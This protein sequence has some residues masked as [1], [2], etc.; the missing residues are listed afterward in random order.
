L[1][2]AKIDDGSGGPVRPDR[3]ETFICSLGGHN[4]VLPHL[5]KLDERVSH[6]R[7]VFD[8]QNHRGDFTNH[9]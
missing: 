1:S 8:N 9:G 2:E 3:V 7:I 5:Q 4:R 6:R